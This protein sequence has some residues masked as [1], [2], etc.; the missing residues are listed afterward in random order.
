[1]IKGEVLLSLSR[2]QYHIEPGPLEKA[3][4]SSTLCNKGG[5]GFQVG[6]RKV[7][8]KLTA[9]AKFLAAQ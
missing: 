3:E 9:I 1:R 6:K 5:H 2:C 4:N 7:K 8:T